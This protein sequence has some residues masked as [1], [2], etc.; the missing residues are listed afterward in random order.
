MHFECVFI[1]LLHATSG[2]LI[3]HHTDSSLVAA[4]AGVMHPPQWPIQASI[5]RAGVTRQVCA[6]EG[7]SLNASEPK[8]SSVW[9]RPKRMP[10]SV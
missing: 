8:D 1:S 4:S 3:S 5:I 10:A 2:W 7:F 9:L 6:A